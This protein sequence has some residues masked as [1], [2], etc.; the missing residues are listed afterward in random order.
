MNCMNKHH[1]QYLRG[2]SPR[3]NYLLAP[4]VAHRIAAPSARSS[5]RMHLFGCTYSDAP[6]RMHLVG[7]C[8]CSLLRHGLNVEA[9]WGEGYP[10]P[11]DIEDLRKAALGEAAKAFATHCLRVTKLVL[12][13]CIWATM[14]SKLLLRIPL[15]LLP[16]G[17]QSAFQLPHGYHGLW[18]PELP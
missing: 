2:P 14:S 3:E 9:S 11:S 8:G 15:P 13:Y 16:I 7:S 18:L 12:S 5:I 6:I 4:F 10:L 1:Q 17:Y